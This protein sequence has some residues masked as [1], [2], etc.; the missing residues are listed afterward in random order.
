MMVDADGT[1]LRSLLEPYR[2]RC[3]FTVAL[4]YSPAI[5]PDGTQIVFVTHRHGETVRYDNYEIATVAID[6]TGFDR[7]TRNGAYD[8][9]PVW[10][11]DGSPLDARVRG[12]GDVGL[13]S[14]V[15]RRGE[16]EEPVPE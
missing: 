8:I 2:D 7:L 13:P 9:N 4:D 15:T 1:N 12:H 6:G 3:N 16:F 10:S 5:S 11:P 14:P